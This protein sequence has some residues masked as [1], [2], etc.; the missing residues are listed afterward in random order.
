LLIGLNGVTGA[1]TTA[2][3][4]T[5]PP[6]AV[7]PPMASYIRLGTANPSAATWPAQERA[8]VGPTIDNTGDDLARLAVAPD[9]MTAFAGDGRDR[10]DAGAAQIFSGPRDGPITVVDTETSGFN[11]PLERGLGG[12]PLDMTGKRAA[13]SSMLLTRG[14]WRDHTDGNRITT[15]RGDKVE[16]IRGNYKLLVLGRTDAVSNGTGVDMSGGCTESD[17]DDLADPLRTTMRPQLNVEYK[18]EQESD[19][20]W[21]WTQTTVQGSEAVATDARGRPHGNGRTVSRTWVDQ[22][23]Q[24]TGSWN[25]RVNKIDQTTYAYETQSISDVE[26][27]AFSWERAGNLIDIVTAGNVMEH[28]AAGGIVEGDIAALIALL[29]VA[30]V[31]P[32][33]LIATVIDEHIGTHV[34]NHV[35]PHVEV[36]GGL[37]TETTLGMHVEAHLGKHV[38]AEMYP[39]TIVGGAS[40][41]NSATHVAT[42][43]NHVSLHQLMHHTASVISCAA[44]HHSIT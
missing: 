18:W 22:I 21:Y 27:L 2:A 19:G 33:V 16:V 13:E 17:P 39:I 28:R 31:I 32:T 8:L 5:T 11:A 26:A 40:S 12:S 9:H 25:R 15:T 6:L 14:G 20:T 1:P 43:D 38:S 37:H 29:Q 44:D 7:D 36:R 4:G 41:F 34:D 10:N 35:G 42:V 24:Q 3:M 23:T 30:A